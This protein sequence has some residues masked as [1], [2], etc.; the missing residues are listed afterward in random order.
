MAGTGEKKAAAPKKL[1]NGLDPS[2]GKKTR[3]KP[4]QVLN[5]KGRPKGAVNLKTLLGRLLEDEGIDWAKVPTKNSPELAKKYGKRGW[6][7]VV[8]VMFAKAVS[9]DVQAAKALAD[10]MYG[11]KVDVTTDGA[12]LMPI[13]LDSTILNRLMHKD[14]GTPPGPEA[15]SEQ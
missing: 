12:P 14:G 6:E 1:Y 10:W 3:I 15:D 2:I 5:P 11:N 8:Y 7:A 9:G 13:A 4:G